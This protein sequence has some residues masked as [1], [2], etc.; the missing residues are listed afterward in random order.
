MD[1]RKEVWMKGKAVGMDRK[2]YGLI[3]KGTDRRKGVCIKGKRYGYTE[4]GTDIR[5]EERKNGKR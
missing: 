4:R 3:E 1:G 2:R 5:K